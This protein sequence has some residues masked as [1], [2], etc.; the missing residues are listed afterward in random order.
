[1]GCLPQH[2]SCRAVPCP[3][4]G[5]EP[6]NPG[7]LRSRTCELNRCA[8]RPAP[9]CVCLFSLEK[10]EAL[11]SFSLSSV[12]WNVTMYLGVGLFSSNVLSIWWSILSHNLCPPV[13]GNHLALFQWRFFF[14]PF[15]L[16][17]LSGPLVWFSKVLIFILHFC[18]FLLCFLEDSLNCPFQSFH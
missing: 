10:A 17:F 12:F 5:S 8:T 16:L 18:I 9:Q 7:P 1:M 11:R 13:L 3:H 4:P 6:A 14:L 15:S 2:G